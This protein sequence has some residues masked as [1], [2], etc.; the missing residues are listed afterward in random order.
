MYY[1]VNLCQLLGEINGNECI[2]KNINTVKVEVCEMK[3]KEV[4]NIMHAVRLYEI[5][6]IKKMNINVLE[7]ALM[8][9]NKDYARLQEGSN[10]TMKAL[11]YNIA[12]KNAKSKENK[13]QINL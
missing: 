9:L 5:Y 2:R 4:A 3:K 12:T 11:Q 1:Y 8:I 13:K 10:K 7:S 6:N